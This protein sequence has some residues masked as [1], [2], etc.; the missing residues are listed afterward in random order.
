MNWLIRIH[1]RARLSPAILWLAARYIDGYIQ[2]CDADHIGPSLCLGATSLYLAVKLEENERLRAS[3]RLGH[4]VGIGEKT[5]TPH[6]VVAM[7]QRLVTIFDG[8]MSIPTIYDFIAHYLPQLEASGVSIDVGI[9]HL[10]AYYAESSLL[11]IGFSKLKASRVGAAVLYAALMCRDQHSSLF[12]TTATTQSIQTSPVSVT[13]T[14][15]GSAHHP[16]PPNPS[17]GDIS[18]QIATALRW[19]YL[20]PP[21]Y[22][23]KPHTLWLP[24]LCQVTGFPASALN[25]V[26]KH[27]V[28]RLVH[29]E[30]FHQQRSVSYEKYSSWRRFSVCH[31]RHPIFPTDITST[32]ATLG[33]PVTPPSHQR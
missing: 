25:E 3:C 13:M 5:F 4:I 29:P 24:Q 14:A 26:A 9:E 28:S 16:S 11:S 8:M 33:P 1:W 19:N 31:L 2:H 32:A 6:D 21:P 20:P 15:N 27:I 12:V 18:N 7:E 22:G 17:S 30:D 23:E 10:S